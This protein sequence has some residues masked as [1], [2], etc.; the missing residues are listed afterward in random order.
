MRITVLN[1]QSVFDLAVR[2]CGT[3]QSAFALAFL[4]GISVT[5][6]LS[7]GEELEIPEAA[8][9][10]IVSYFNSRNHQPATA[11]NRLR[12]LEGISHWAIKVDF[13]VTEE[14]E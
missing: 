8:E 14:H 2:Y 11:W 1:N 13:E 10:D 6:T 9:K 4:N 3:V 5:T 7:P 12:V